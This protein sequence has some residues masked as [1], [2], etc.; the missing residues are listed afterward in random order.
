MS[1]D[2]VSIKI[3]A[4]KK[5]LEAVRYNVQ[6]TTGAK[7]EFWQREDKRTLRKIEGLTK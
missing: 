4:L 7:Q 5:Y 1:K 2:N 6:L 3:T